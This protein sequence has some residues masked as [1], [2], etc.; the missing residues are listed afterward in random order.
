MSLADVPWVFLIAASPI[1]ELRG[2]IPL[3]IH[4][5]DF[6]WYTAFL[7]CFLGNIFPVPFLLILLGPI[8][9]FASRVRLFD[10]IM[11]WVFERTRRRGAV[12]E[13]Y[14][15]LGL[16]LFVCIP[17]PGTGAWT[18]SLAAFL[19]GLEFKK[20]LLSIVAGVFIAA[21][22][23]TVLSLLGWAGVAIAGVALSILFALGFWRI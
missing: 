11:N 8:S 3:A 20:A 1:V 17:L 22:I 12:V 7:V 5:Y 16:V 18:G 13:K 6:P 23:V 15:R 10:S 2:A 21:I 4:D 14:E 9:R 19:F